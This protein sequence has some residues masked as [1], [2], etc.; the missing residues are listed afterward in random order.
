[1]GIE[2]EER[3]SAVGPSRVGLI[4]HCPGSVQMQE[5]YPGQNLHEDEADEGKEMHKWGAE[6]LAHDDP[7]LVVPQW[8]Y[9]HVMTYVNDVLS[10]IPQVFRR[11]LK[12][13]HPV[14][15]SSIHPDSK[16]TLDCGCI[17]ERTLYVWEFKGGYVPVDEYENP[18]GANYAIGFLD[19]FNAWSEVDRVVIRIV[20]PRANCLRG[21]IRTWKTTPQ[22]LLPVRE[23]I[24]RAIE[25]AMDVAPRIISGAHCRNCTAYRQCPATQQA[26]SQ[27]MEVADI[28]SSLPRD[29]N[30]GEKLKEAK[31]AAAL[32][33]DFIDLV[34]PVIEGRIRKGGVEPGWCM[35]PKSG[36]LAWKDPSYA[37]VVESLTGVPLHIAPVTPTQA[38][39]LNVPEA[40]LEPFVERK[41]KMVL[42]EDLTWRLLEG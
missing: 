37:K 31:K 30:L 11:H 9:R 20:Q 5:L 33:K 26:V 29:I 24:A 15:A 7:E 25:E 35:V 1:M 19:T 27:V 6:V 40:I 4:M 32:L 12:V 14:F 13:E 22:G 41:S 2:Q 17:W 34:E 42:A 39:E 38:M 21:K 10:I 18:Q 28:I 23:K 8:C 16:G 36:R 3:H